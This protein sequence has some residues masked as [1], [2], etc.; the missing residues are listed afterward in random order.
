M[1]PAVQANKLSQEELNSYVVGSCSCDS[2]KHYDGVYGVSECE[3]TQVAF[4]RHRNMHVRTFSV[5]AVDPK[6]HSR[7]R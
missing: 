2:Q 3:K 4:I 5:F 7:V 1:I 6:T